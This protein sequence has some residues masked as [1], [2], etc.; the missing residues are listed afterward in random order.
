[1]MQRTPGTRETGADAGAPPFATLRRAS[2]RIP[3]KMITDSSHRERPPTPSRESGSER[4]VRPAF[5][6]FYRGLAAG[7]VDD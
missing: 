3:L 4:A 6:L 1:M 7:R 2:L 5:A